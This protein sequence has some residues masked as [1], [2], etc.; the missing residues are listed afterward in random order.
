MSRWVFALLLAAVA[1]AQ[2]RDAQLA[3][4]VKDFSTSG[5]S[6]I[7][8]RVRSICAAPDDLSTCEGWAIFTVLRLQQ[9]GG[10]RAN[11]L[12]RAILTP[13]RELRHRVNGPNSENVR[14]LLSLGETSYLLQD[15]SAAESVLRAALDAL[16]KDGVEN[17][18]TAGALTDLA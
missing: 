11:E 13:V 9:T 8:A 2:N 14:I 1:F 16:K 18:L 6:E 17:I 3:Q 15:Y 12:A 10:N 4:I 7:E 5:P